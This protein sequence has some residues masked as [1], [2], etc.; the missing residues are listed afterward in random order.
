L[1]EESFV[2]RFPPY[3]ERR[4]RLH[5][6]IDIIRKLWT[7]EE[8]FDY[9]GKYYPLKNII[10]YTRPKPP[11]PIIISAFGEQSGALAGQM[12]DGIIIFWNRPQQHRNRT[13]QRFEQTAKKEGK[14]PTNMMKAAFFQTGL[15][16]DPLP[17]VQMMKSSLAWSSPELLHEADPRGFDQ[18]VSEIPIEQALQYYNPAQTTDDMITHFEPALKAGFTNLIIFDLTPFFVTL[19]LSPPEALDWPQKVIPYLKEQYK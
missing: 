15:A 5:E 12:G 10:L 9:D 7:S 4:E 16:S 18:K 17:L 2:G 13:I 11:I 19:K 1:N 3:S 6:A 8:H 14:D